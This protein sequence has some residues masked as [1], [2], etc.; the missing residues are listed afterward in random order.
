MPL[1][2][3][4]ISSTLVD[5]AMEK[6]NEDYENMMKPQFFP[7]ASQ[8]NIYYSRKLFSLVFQMLKVLIAIYVEIKNGNK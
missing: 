6:A 1:K 2:D 3:I 7:D 8:V 4:K 5:D